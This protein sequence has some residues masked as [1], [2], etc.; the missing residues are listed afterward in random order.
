MKLKAPYRKWKGMCFS[1]FSVVV[2]S[3]KSVCGYAEVA[4][5]G[6]D[7]SND[8][9][10]VELYADS[11]EIHDKKGMAL[12]DGNVSVIQGKRLLQTSKLVVYYDKMHKTVNKYM[13]NTETA[14]P[15]WFGSTSIKKVEALG[16]VSIKIATQVATGD[17]GVF[18][19]KS[20]IMVLTGSNVVLTDGENVVTGCKL[21]ANMKTGKALLEG[22]E[23]S[24]KKRRV[25]IILKQNQENSH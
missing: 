15:T 9:E 25:S 17:K 7:I 23:T 22:C 19:G 6:I 10:S 2:L 18:D 13:V 5:F 20:N 16:K 3:F 8:K 4:N 14:L 21:T 1:A 12:F 24:K 11:L